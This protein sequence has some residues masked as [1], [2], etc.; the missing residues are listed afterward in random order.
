MARGT[1]IIDQIRCK[2]CTLCLAAC[3][4]EV[5]EMD[6]NVLNAKGYHPAVLVDPEGK[7]TGCAICTVV[8]PD[9]CITVYREVKVRA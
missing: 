1:I 3:P 2:G 9:A 6:N 7:C 5:I 4:Q 8:C